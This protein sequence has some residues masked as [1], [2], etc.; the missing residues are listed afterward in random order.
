MYQNKCIAFIPARSGSKRI[1]NKNIKILSNHPL[2][3]YSI[4][5]AKISGIFSRVIVSTDSDLIAN[6]AR[7]Y[8]AEVP[9]LRPKKFAQ[10]NSEDI[11][12]LQYTLR[13]L[14]KKSS[15]Y[16]ILRPTSPFRTVTMIQN[17]WKMLLDDPKAD[18]IRAVEKC[19]QH[20]AKMWKV[21]GNRMKPV[22]ENPDPSGI[23]WFSTPMQVLPEIYMQNSSLEIAKTQIPL[24]TNSISGK[25]IIPYI[26]NGF[27]GYDLN[28]EK[29]WIY[30]EYLIETKRVK[31]PVIL[32]D[33]CLRRQASTLRLSPDWSG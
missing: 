13:K 26:T 9:F 12:W 4:Q 15:Y 19:A 1:P 6:I 10:E 5:I 32:R 28:T 18:S 2:I 16:A 23:E 31:L 24:T 25:Q 33:P 22:I 30:A 21:K 11:N 17:A 20:P 29:D 3:A 27:E 7:Y 14:N 8:G